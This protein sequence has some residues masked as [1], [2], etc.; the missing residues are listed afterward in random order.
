MGILSL[1]EDGGSRKLPWM[2]SEPEYCITRSPFTLGILTVKQRV[3][4]TRAATEAE[5][6]ENG[7]E[8]I[9]VAKVGAG[10]QKKR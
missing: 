3:G 9:G 6:K 4:Y 8:A 2:V 1:H 10:G 7:S 5:V